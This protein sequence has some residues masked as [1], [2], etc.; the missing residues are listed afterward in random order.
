MK[1]EEKLNQLS[2]TQFE[3]LTF[4]LLVLSGLRN[5]VWRTPGTDAGRD[6]EGEY[7]VTDFSESVRTEKWYIECKRYSSS[8][9]WPTV[10]KKIAYSTNHNADFLLF[11]TSSYISPRCK[12]E[13][14]KWNLKRDSLKLRFWDGAN[15]G[16]FLNRFPELSIKY[17]LTDEL[18]IQNESILPILLILSKAIQSTYSNSVFGNNDNSPIEL[19]ASLVDMISARLSEID[20][21]IS[22]LSNKRFKQERDSYDWCTIN[23]DLS[24]LDGYGVRCV[25]CAIK[26]CFNQEVVVNHQ[27]DNDNVFSV[28]LRNYKRSQ[29]FDDIVKHIMIWSNIEVRITGNEVNFN[30]R[31]E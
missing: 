15:I 18:S 14:Q 8:I 21:G 4:D 13:I 5:A 3:N 20:N 22:F 1:I 30:G 17:G 7:H 16:R 9:D 24:K 10:Y 31:F 2:S 6:I 25:F 27:K 12:E 29:V 11:V 28:E 23:A 19:S 26:F